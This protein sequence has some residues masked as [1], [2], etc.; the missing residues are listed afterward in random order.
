MY[1]GLSPIRRDQG[2]WEAMKVG[3]SRDVF[4]CHAS[5]DK[6]SVVRPLVYALESAGISCWYDEA[7]ILWGDSLTGRVNEGLRM[8]KFILVV[9]SAD[10]VEKNWPR[11]ELEA[12]LNI[13]ASSGEVRVLP[14]LVGNKATQDGIVAHLPLL[15]HKKY[16]VWQDD[17]KPIV[18][19]LLRRLGRK[20]SEKSAGESGPTKR[21]GPSGPTVPMP[22]LRRE[23]SERDKDRFV[24]ESFAE[25]RKYFNEGLDQLQSLSS[26]IETDLDDLE[27]YKFVATVYRHGTVVSRCK[28]W[29]GGLTR[30]NETICYVEGPYIAPGDNSMNDW[31][32]VT[33]DGA[34]LGLEPSGLGLSYHSDLK[35]DAALTAEE[36][37]EYLWRRFL[38]AVE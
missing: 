31:L 7:E 12:V 15:N 3:E 22:A 10:S 24:R 35:D 20:R 38:R 4:V 37:A 16:E 34:K 29:I 27:K 26:D 14:L 17:P 8:S 2:C 28:V 13:E 25:I 36:A 19:A 1:E 6:E 9:L 33:N 5:E 11:M 18:E 30:H 23:F 21:E 32:S